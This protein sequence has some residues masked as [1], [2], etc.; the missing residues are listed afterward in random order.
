MIALWLAFG[1]YAEPAPADEP[2]QASIRPVEVEAADEGSDT[3]VVLEPAPDR[4][5][6]EEAPVPEPQAVPA[7]EPVAPEPVDPE[8]VQVRPVIEPP[9]VEPPPH[10][11]AVSVPHPEFVEQGPAWHPV[12]EPAG[13]SVVEEPEA[14]EPVVAEEPVHPEPRAVAVPTALPILPAEGPWTAVGLLG[15]AV[16]AWLTAVGAQF[17]AT[18]LEPVGLLP[19]L[20]RGVQALGRAGAVFAVLGALVAMRP[21]GPVATLVVI[22]GALAIG[23]SLRDALPDL[24]AWIMLIA[25]GRIRSGIWVRT[26]TYAGR[27]DVVS[28]RSTTV[29]GADGVQTAVPNR[30]LLRDTVQISTQ[31]F[32]WVD[33]WVHVPGVTP[34]RTHVALRDAVSLSPWVAPRGVVEIGQDPADGTRWRVRVELLDARFT[35]RFEGTLQARIREVLTSRH[36]SI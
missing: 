32:R 36:T 3:G 33:V 8:P 19:S 31:P 35:E 2:D 34:D 1:A 6:I 18:R 11:T 24:I 30:A 14:V 21:E 15:V 28:P 5:P 29:R 23:W 25:E 20:A 16:L 10:D 27:V 26:A 13:E 12:S 9:V 7:P 22:G 4:E 17:F